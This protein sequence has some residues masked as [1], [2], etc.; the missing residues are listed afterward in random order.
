MLPS[1]RNA[2]T[3]PL[4]QRAAQS[5]RSTLV[6]QG[7]RVG[8]KALGVV[9]LAR[10][11]SPADHGRYA[12]AATVFF[13]L[14]LFRDLGLGTAAVQARELNEE[15]CSTLFWAHLWLGLL[16]GALTLALAPVAAFFYAEPQLIGLLSAMAGAFVLL[17][18]N[19]WPRVLLNRDLHFADT[20]RLETIAALVGTITMILAAA[21]GAGAYAFAM[22]LLVSEAVTLAAAWRVC[23]WRPH[24]AARWQ[25]LRGLWKTSAHVTG[26]QLLQTVAQQVDSALMG[27]W[28][29]PTALGLYNR[30]NQL[31]ALP[32]QHASGPLTHVLAATL[33]RVG[34]QGEDFARHLYAATTSIAHLTLPVAAV[35][36]ALPEEV[37]RLILGPEW[38][39]AAPLLHWLGLSWAATYLGSTV[40]AVC[41]ATGHARRLTLLT[42]ALLGAIA[43]GVWFGRRQGPEGIAAG[44][45]LA[46]ASL[47]LPRLW[48]ATRGVPVQFGRYVGALLGPALLALALIA[49][50]RA[51]V[52][53]LDTPDWRWR[54]GSGLGGAGL[55][56]VLV[57]FVVPRVRRELT[58][59]WASP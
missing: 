43:L 12:M 54:L 49:G 59:C 57:L 2:E 52:A 10:L 55:A 11:V 33:A 23:R 38:P 34:P 29:G 45:A 58:R 18:L 50:G 14:V 26:Y 42:G 48:W 27:H 46:Q 31:L 25:S 44:V 28:F 9:V 36:I 37:V 4:W 15:Q 5:Y 30:P 19:S 32:H 13:V 47:L 17:G 6:S 1:S 39:G 8:V 51:G 56:S 22:F 24:A 7:I 53:I 16:L 40:Y 35:C 3:A 21:A 41:I 20:S